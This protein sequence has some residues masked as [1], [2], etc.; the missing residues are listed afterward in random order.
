MPLDPYD[1]GPAYAE[2]TAAERRAESN[3]AINNAV[4]HIVRRNVAAF[5]EK[6]LGDL[7]REAPAAL[8]NGSYVEEIFYVDGEAYCAHRSAAIG[9]VAPFIEESVKEFITT[10]DERVEDE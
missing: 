4:D 6:T 8:L 1:P 10:L 5:L 2:P 7:R 9:R 3:A